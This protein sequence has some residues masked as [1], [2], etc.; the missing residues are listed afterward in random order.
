[1]MNFRFTNIRISDLKII[2][3]VYV[4]DKRGFFIKVYERDVFSDAGVNFSIYETFETT[5]AC[6]TIRGMHFQ[7]KEPQAKLVRVIKGEIFDVVVDLRRGSSTF[8]KWEG[9]YLSEGNRK[10][11]LIPKG[12]AHGFIALG[13]ENVVSYMC[14]GRYLNEFDTGI[15]WNDKD[16]NIKWPIPHEIDVIVSDKDKGLMTF[17]DFIGKHGG[18]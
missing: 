18:L 13:T 10:M 12:F 2:N 5:S 14:D 3:P 16:L 9:F 11:L 6:G 8:G 17:K 4:D 1:M 7:T 15:V